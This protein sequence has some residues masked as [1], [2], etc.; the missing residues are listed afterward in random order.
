MPTVPSDLRH[1]F[2]SP[3]L[4]LA[5]GILCTV[6]GGCSM[7]GL[8]E[9]SNGP[10]HV[11]SHPEAPKPDKLAETRAQMQASPREPYW[12]HHMA[13]LYL[14]A[15][16]TTEAIDALKS[17]LAIDSAYAP[18]VSLL[19]HIYYDAHMY[20]QAVTLLE[21]YLAHNANAP[22]A[23]RAA[24]ALNYEA[25]GDATKADAALASCTAGAR[26]A[27]CA[28]VLARLRGS[29][30]AAT[31]SEAKRALDDDSKSAANHNNYGIALLV[32][33][34]PM[35]AR[36]QFRAALDLDGKNPGALYNMAIVETF[37]FFN[38]DTGRQWYARYLKVDNEDPDNLKA[39][40][41][42]AVTTTEPAPHEGK[43]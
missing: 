4:A 37:Y 13:E 33:G 38:D 31:L 29:D 26:D 10:V 9:K 3:V 35:D 28:R 11:E 6:L 41:E 8:G 34:K 19:S 36:D 25:L 12:P 20:P 21:D 27:D 22:D 2:A 5:L 18:S 40:F 23:Q 16:S 39:H 24:L 17:A 43:P 30:S 7:L 42:S 14:A 15:D 32:A 1:D